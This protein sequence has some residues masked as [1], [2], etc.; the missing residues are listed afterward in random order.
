MSPS[1]QSDLK[2]IE[3]IKTIQEKLEKTIL[4]ADEKLKNN[5]IDEAKALYKEAQH[6]SLYNGD[7][8]KVRIMSEDADNKKWHELDVKIKSL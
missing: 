6:L 5:L 1:I 3:E 4:L 8:L 2:A 7:G